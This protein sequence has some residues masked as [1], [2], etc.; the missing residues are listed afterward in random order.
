MRWI[1]HLSTARHDPNIRLLCAEF[2][3]EGYGVY[4]TILETIATD[5]KFTDTRAVATMDK[6]QW[7][8]SVKISPKKFQKIL[9]FCSENFGFLVENGNKLIT[10]ECPK[11]LKYRDEWTNRKNKELGSNS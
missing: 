8:N 1:K 10:I 3:F 4:W 5:L 11:L 6:Q 2:G 9:V 7:C